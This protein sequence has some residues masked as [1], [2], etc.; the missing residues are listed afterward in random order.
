MQPSTTTSNKLKRIVYG[1]I[2]ALVLIVAGGIA[3]YIFF[4]SPPSSF[5]NGSVF[6]IESGQG[7]GSVANELK[8]DN[9]VRSPFLFRS[10]VIFFGGER[11]TSAGLYVFDKPENVFTVAYRISHRNYGY[12]AIKITIPE[13]ISA[14]SIADLV[15]DKFPLIDRQ[16]FFQKILPFE[17]YLFPETYFFPPQAPASMI[18]DR[19]KYQF[20]KN[21][22]SLKSDFTA[23]DR[24]KEDIIIVA[25]ILEEEVKTDIDRKKVADIIWRRLSAGIPLQVDSTVA[26]VI[27]RPA[28]QLTAMDLKKA[29]P[30]NTYLNKGLPPTPISNPGKESILAALHPTANKY[31]YFLSG[32][33]GIT[34]FAVTYSEHV[35]NIKKY[36]R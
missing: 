36:L 1:I 8:I 6:I 13:G 30:Y 35:K 18:V 31:L 11:T 24:S 20:N 14:A 16:E 22:D 32:K 27:G 7:L 12:S 2:F 21:I 25:S 15:H 23:S 29:S 33:D 19:L 26:Y 17:G 34:H 10:L 9:M 3:L 28:N 4:V 5:K